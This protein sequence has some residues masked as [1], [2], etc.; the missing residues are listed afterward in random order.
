MPGQFDDFLTGLG[1]GAFKYASTERARRRQ[2][3]DA[4]IQFQIEALNNMMETGNINPAHFSRVVSDLLDLSK[5]KSVSGRKRKPG[6]AG[7]LGSTEVP[8][9]SFLSDIASGKQAIQGSP[10]QRD[11]FGTGTLREMPGAAGG[12]DPTTGMSG[13][14]LPPEPLPEISPEQRRR[15]QAAEPLLLSPQYVAERDAEIA[16]G[17]AEQGLGLV[18]STAA[19]GSRGTRAGE[20]E[21][22][23]AALQGILGP[24]V[25]PE[26]AA[27]GSG[28][29]P[30]P[31]ARSSRSRTP[32]DVALSA[33]TAGT[34]DPLDPQTIFTAQELLDA[35]TMTANQDLQE[36]RNQAIMDHQLD[37]GFLP[38]ELQVRS[39]DAIQRAHDIAF[40]AANDAL[41]FPINDVNVSNATAMAA[42]ALRPASPPSAWRIP[43]AAAPASA[44]MPSEAG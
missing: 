21:A 39:R 35:R 30:V 6:G 14:G 29:I 9:S 27:Q 26:I 1:S 8:Q 20:I 19:A 25:D 15:M 10:V 18:E 23:Q 34:K 17:V 43:S 36:W 42:G 33:V 32:M 24:G 16:R 7:Y 40:Q 41:A 4:E 28:L 2:E 5:G 44:T 12:I 11:Q 13:V 22:E 37:L 31:P 3:E 38:Q